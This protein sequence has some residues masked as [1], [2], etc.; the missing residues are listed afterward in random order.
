MISA[1]LG[2]QLSS[3]CNPLKYLRIGALRAALAQVVI[4]RL[5]NKV[6]ILAVKDSGS[7]VASQP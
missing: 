2:W 1:A 6:A 5:N 7:H 4:K 3:M